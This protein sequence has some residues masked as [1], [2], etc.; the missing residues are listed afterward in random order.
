MQ[1]SN[2]SFN[3]YLIIFMALVQLSFAMRIVSTAPGIT[4]TL[5]FLGAT[6][7]V[8]AVS[9]YCDYPEQVSSLPKVG[10]YYDINKEM[11]IRLSPDIV[12]MMDGNEELKSFLTKHNIKLKYKNYS[13]T[14]IEDLLFSIKDI[15]KEINKVDA[16]D[17]LINEIS[18][19][20]EIIKNKNFNK[21]TRSV[22]LIIDQDLQQNKLESAFVVGQ[23]KYYL[24][25]LRLFNLENVVKTTV[26]YPRITKETIQ[27]LKPEVILVFW[28]ASLEQYDWLFKGDYKPQIY[29]FKDFFMRRPGPRILEMLTALEN[30]L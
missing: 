24:P 26:P 7:D 23:D 11:M 17:T 29:I 25:I 9:R 10:G 22:L 15:G 16:A 2:K 1:A 18:L 4:E 12:F 27:Y 21:K 30:V 3:K 19:K 6:D 13:T 28:E 20:M 5:F 14:S 8:I